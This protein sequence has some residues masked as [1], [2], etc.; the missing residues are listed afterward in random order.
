MRT[1]LC[2]HMKCGNMLTMTML[3]CVEGLILTLA[4]H[5]S[6]ANYMYISIYV[7]FIMLA[8]TVWRANFGKLA[9]VQLKLMVTSFADNLVTKKHLG[10]C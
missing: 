10:G 8:I 5:V 3:T 1:L 6:M 9:Q 7:M 4:K 2:F